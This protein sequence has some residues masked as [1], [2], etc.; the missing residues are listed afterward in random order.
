MTV[1]PGGLVAI[2]VRT[3][4]PRPISQGQLSIRGGAARARGASPFAAIESW[5]VFS[6]EG[7][8]S[9]SATL[10][11]NGDQI[12]LQFA[13]VSA[14]VNDSDGPMLVVYAWLD[15]SYLAGTELE[16]SLDALGTA[17]V[18]EYGTPIEVELRSGTLSVVAEGTALA[19]GAE[20][21][22]ALPGGIARLGVITEQV[23]RWMSGYLEFNYPSE[24]AA[25][26]PLVAI[27]P[28]YG[29]ASLVVQHPEP[30][31]VTISF[32]SADFSLNHL[33]GEVLQ[34]D[35]PLV[36]DAPQNSTWPVSIDPATALILAPDGNPIPLEV[37]PGFFFV[38]EVLFADGFESG[39]ASVWS[40]TSP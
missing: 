2:V 4:T 20:G 37:H 3:Y 26:L 32:L 29:S 24:I 35:L 17:V 10:D 6:S 12:Q 8:A 27:D 21:E 14:S 9:G 1:T 13:S 28:R 22:D 40:A 36:S 30:G 23:Q 38:G 25:A 5:T 16:V 15:G 7:D 33:P 19:I 18:D 39:D 11:P 34:I 31:R